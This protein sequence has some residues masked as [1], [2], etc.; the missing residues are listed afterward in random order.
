VEGGGF[1]PDAAR[2]LTV[3]SLQLALEHYRAD[4]DSYPASLAN[5]FPTYAPLGRDGKTMLGPPAASDGYTYM[6]TGSSYTLSVV[7]ANG[8][9]YT[10]QAPERP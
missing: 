10:V 4:Q 5:L 3:A 1:T 6:T 2:I 7:M 8:Q 9:A